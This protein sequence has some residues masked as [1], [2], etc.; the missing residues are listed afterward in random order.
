MPTATISGISNK[1]FQFLLRRFSKPASSA[2]FFHGGSVWCDHQAM[3]IVG[4]LYSTPF[5]AKGFLSASNMSDESDHSSEPAPTPAES[6]PRSR[7]ISNPRPKKKAAKSAPVKSKE[8]PPVDPEPEEQAVPEVEVS[9]PAPEPAPEVETESATGDTTDTDD[10]N[11]T[12][13]ADWPEPEAESSGGLASPQESGKRKRRRRKG[14]GQGG[15]QNQGNAE[16]SLSEKPE[17]RSSEPTAD[18]RP[19]PVQAPQNPPHPQP[20]RPRVDPEQVVKMAWKIYLAEVS[21]EGVALIGDQDAKD[22]S[23]R[24]FRLA[25][26]FIE[27]QSRRR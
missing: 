8:A 1:P 10:A 27:E 7:R 6:A 23:R 24:C 14:K 20:N 26:I 17:S 12:N 25:E 21:E 4:E 22:L 9:A 5:A 3:R 13:D 11:G 19:R 16:E 15:Q 18:V 2:G